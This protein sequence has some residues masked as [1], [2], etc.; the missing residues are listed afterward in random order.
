[1]D[2][3]WARIRKLAGEEFQTSRGLPF[4]YEI[5]GD[6]IRPSRAKQNIGKDEF[7]KAPA[8]VPITGPGQISSLVRG[9]AYIW[10]ALHD[11]RTRKLEW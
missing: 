4:T 7:A 5:A 1:M 2:A 6:A 8:L 11:R 10:A 9:S 3:V